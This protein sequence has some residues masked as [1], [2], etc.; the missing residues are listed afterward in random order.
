MMISTVDDGELEELLTKGIRTYLVY[1]Y[2]NSY[3]TTKDYEWLRSNT[4]IILRK[5]SFFGSMWAKLFKEKLNIIVV[6]QKTLTNEEQVQKQNSPNASES[7][8]QN[9]S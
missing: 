3:I 8:E 7:S 6:E 5:P 4:A 9:K 1:L 2:N